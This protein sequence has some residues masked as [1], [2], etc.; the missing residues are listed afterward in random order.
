MKNKKMLVAFILVSIVGLVGATYAY[1]TT[2]STLTNKFNAGVYATLV[3]EEFISPENWTPGTIT[4][5][6]VN[7]LNTGTVE[8]ALRAS[9]N[10]SWT[11]VNGDILANERNSEKIAQL[12]IGSDWELATDGYY[13]YKLTLK[14]GEKSSDFISSV[15]F[16]PNFTLEEGFDIECK[17]EVKETGNSSKCTSLTSGYSGATYKLDVTIETIQAD[18]KWSY[19]VLKNYTSGTSITI[20][21]EEFNIIKDNGDTVTM[22]AANNLGSD[23]K[24]TSE[25]VA[26]AFSDTNGWEY[27]PGP[28]EINIQEYDGP[29]KTYVNGYETYLREVTGDDEV[30]VDLI[31]LNQLKELGCS[32]P[33]DYSGGQASCAGSDNVEW[34][35]NEHYW[36]TKS[37]A[38]G[39]HTG[40]W[41]V[42]PDGILQGYFYYGE[43]SVRPVVTISKETLYNY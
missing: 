39:N 4:P 16:N 42:R 14:E 25:E 30:I 27:Y 11:A 37:A 18:Q 35:I 12:A 29:V 7:A 40:V 23:F 5:K 13:Y 8:I 28:K 24:Q 6:R 36:W 21:N 20:E 31:T 33:D 41:L 3:E 10:E 9:Y 43:L 1:F 34:L 17:N 22:L 2:T 19:K 38:A 15:T 26:V 32:I